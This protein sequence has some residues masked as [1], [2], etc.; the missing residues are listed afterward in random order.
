MEERGSL[1]TRCT[2]GSA[3][4]LSKAI[5]ELLR[6]SHETGNVDLIDD[7]GDSSDLKKPVDK[8]FNPKTLKP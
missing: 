4:G 5:Q 2:A 6:I 7:A 1:G 8:G 3:K